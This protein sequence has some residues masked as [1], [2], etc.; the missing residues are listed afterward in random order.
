MYKNVV[1]VGTGIYYPE[2]NVKTREEIVDH[3][4]TINIDVEGLLNH[5]GKE[6]RF[7]ADSNETPLTIA[8][9]AAQEALKTS[10]LS[11]DDIDM[12]VFST[13]TPEYTI[14]AN[15]VKLAHLLNAKNA[16]VLYDLNANCAGG[17]IALDQ[18]NN[19]MKSHTQI[20]RALVIGS[21]MG[22]YIHNECE[23][24]S[25]SIFTDGAGAVILEK[26]EEPFERG[27]IDSEYDA[28]GDYHNMNAFPKNGFNEILRDVPS[29]EDALKLYVKP[30]VQLSFV[31]DVWEKIVRSL[32][33]RNSLTPQAIESYIC[34]QFSLFDIKSTLDK[35]E[36]NQSKKI[37]VGDK[38]G[39]TGSSSP[40]FAL[41][42]A[43]KNNIIKKNSYGIFLGIGSGYTSISIL[44]K[45]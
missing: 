35:L 21:F 7:I 17:V 24:L 41:N 15:A 27:F 44:Y 13:D 2:K 22:S 40:I 33:E 5:L 16:N 8:Q 3:F 4:K 18:V 31:P 38:Y 42:S 11:I 39:Y 6:R 10:N 30:D 14:P 32:L 36:V 28:S 29:D 34:S 43:L 45:Y 20:N 1:I 26:E 19:F 37:Y 9:K 12:I 25:Y 23:A